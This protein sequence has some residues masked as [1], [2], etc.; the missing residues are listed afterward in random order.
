M[1][2]QMYRN[3]A[4]SYRTKMRLKWCHFEGHTG[5]LRVLRVNLW[6]IRANLRLIWIKVTFKWDDLKLYNEQN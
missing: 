1:N 5:Q 6:V 3:Y 4:V 2:R